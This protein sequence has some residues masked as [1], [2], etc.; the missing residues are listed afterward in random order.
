[1]G[2]GDR[3]IEDI[4]K[5]AESLLDGQ[6]V[7][8]NSRLTSKSFSSKSGSEISSSFHHSDS[9][10]CSNHNDQHYFDTGQNSHQRLTN[11]TQTLDSSALDTDKVWLQTEGCSKEEPQPVI[12]V[13]KGYEAFMP[14]HLVG[15][16]LEVTYKRI[17]EQ[18]RKEV[19]GSLKTHLTGEFPDLRLSLPIPG[20][21]T[22]SND[23]PGCFNLEQEF[24]EERKRC[25]KLKGTLTG[26]QVLCQ[27]YIYFTLRR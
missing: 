16:P 26:L 23:V 4:L 10:K 13:M 2:G 17:Y 7:R 24:L 20:L 27:C 19:G 14:S 6:Q 1:M 12:K 21:E 8:F 3:N 9:A 11:V 15:T 5:E 25:L 18:I 22:P